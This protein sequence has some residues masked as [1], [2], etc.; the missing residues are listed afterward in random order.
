MIVVFQPPGG[1]GPLVRYSA[2]GGQKASNLALFYF[3][4]SDI[5]GN[6]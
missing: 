4:F 5:L 1:G 6:D 2:S 3:L